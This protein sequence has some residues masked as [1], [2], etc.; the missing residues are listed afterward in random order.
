M[1]LLARLESSF[2]PEIRKSGEDLAAGGRVTLERDELATE[3]VEHIL[4]PAD[5]RGRFAW[6]NRAVAAVSAFR[7]RSDAPLLIFNVAATG[8]GKTIANAKLACVASPRPRFAIALN[9]R[10]LTLQT[11]DALRESLGLGADEMAT[12][13][14]DR[15]A[16]R[17]FAGLLDGREQQGDENCDDCN[18]HQQFDQCKST[19]NDR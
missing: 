2:K 5:E 16:A 17:G 9:L 19:A 7:A 6:Q 12:V 8:A 18:D 1:S 15:V 3:T 13:I 11:G 10:T 14:G 4:S